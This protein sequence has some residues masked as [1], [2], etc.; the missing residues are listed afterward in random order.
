M[1]VLIFATALIAVLIAAA[2]ARSPAGPIIYLEQGWTKTLRE[3]FYFTPQG[4]HMMPADWFE[5]LEQPEGQG[6]FG[7]PAYLQRFGF[8]V[9]ETPFETN[10]NGYPIGFAVEETT[11][12]IGLTC[13]ACHTANVEVE[14]QTIR[15]DGAP[16]HLDFDGF[17]QNLA[18]AVSRTLLDP[19]KFTRF[20]AA[21]GLATDEDVAALR[22]E[23][24]AFDLR[25]T[26]DAALRRP[27]LA[28]GFGRV[29]ALTQ[30]VNALAAR[31]QEK[32]ANLFPVAAPTSYPALWLTPELEFVQWNPIA[33]SPIARNGGQVLG[34]FGRTN[35]AHDAGEDAFRSS[36]L[37][38][39]L[40]DLEE[41]LQLLEPPRWDEALMGAI[42][43]DLAAEGAELFRDNCK[44]CH[45]MAPY[46]RTDPIENH[47]GET[48]IKIGR[49]DFRKVG[50]DS[51]YSTSLLTRRIETNETTAPLFEGEEIVPAFSFFGGLVGAAVRRAIEDAG[52]TPEESVALSGFKFRTGDDG[53]PVPYQ[54]PSF[55]DLKASPLAGVWATGPYLHNGSVPTIYELLSPVEER[56]RVFW[57]GGRALDLRNLG[58][59]SDE[60]LGRFRFDTSLQGN[61]NIGHLYPPRGFTPA[62]RMAVIEYLKTQ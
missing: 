52:F 49:V 16:A 30:I 17:Y 18:R 28:S 26:G 8:I 32:P 27:V 11:G 5:A 38:P 15:V 23:L 22:S 55:T 43:A 45:N 4:S 25:L 42:D 3:N 1:R 54:P 44:A 7:D 61:R 29:D 19:E 33:A 62:E 39:Q 53:Q 10:G 48:F 31:D 56:R 40:K 60:A 35:L 51:A 13:A 34:V 24:A 50:T 46:A 36:M 20:G 9:P 41:W 59:E 47:F 14:G 12:Q 57:T 2:F 21:L 6:R 37:L 58:Y